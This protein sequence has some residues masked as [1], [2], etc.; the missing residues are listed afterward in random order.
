MDAKKLRNSAL[1]AKKLLLL[2]LKVKK[3]KFALELALKAKRGSRDI[4]LLF[5]LGAEWGWVIN[6]TPRTHCTG[7]W[8][9]SRT[10]LDGC[11]KSRPHRH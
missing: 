9:R 3:V 6:A 8:I 2:L 11:G 7:T 1:S 5:N 4:A 10:S